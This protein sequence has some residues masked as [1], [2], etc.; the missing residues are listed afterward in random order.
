M[1]RENSIETR[2]RKVVEESAKH[3]LLKGDGEMEWS[4]DTIDINLVT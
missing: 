2:V 4:E 1:E 3:E